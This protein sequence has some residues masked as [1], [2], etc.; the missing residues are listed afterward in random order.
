MKEQYLDH[1]D[2]KADSNSSAAVV[3]Q[4]GARKRHSAAGSGSRVEIDKA[5]ATAKRSSTRRGL[6]CASTSHRAGHGADLCAHAALSAPCPSSRTLK[7]TAVGAASRTTSACSCVQPLPIF[8]R[9]SHHSS[10]ALFFDKHGWCPAGFCCRCVSTSFH[11][12]MK[13]T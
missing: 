3:V 1:S 12:L 10:A 11:V 4:P 6:R 2:I 13:S 9:Q 7:E 5:K 8:A